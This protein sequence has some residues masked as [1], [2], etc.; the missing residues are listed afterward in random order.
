MDTHVTGFSNHTQHGF[1]KEMRYG[2]H[3]AAIPVLDAA[4]DAYEGAALVPLFLAPSKPET[5]NIRGVNRY[6]PAKAALQNRRHALRTA[7]FYEKNIL[8]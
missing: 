8:K 6:I 3:T 5:R 2:V 4:V 1:Y 7:E